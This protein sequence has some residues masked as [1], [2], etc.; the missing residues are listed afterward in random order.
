M[1]PLCLEAGDVVDWSLALVISHLH[2][3]D[4]TTT[5]E[6]LQTKTVLVQD[7]KLKAQIDRLL[8]QQT[9]ALSKRCSF[10]QKLKRTR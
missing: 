9:Q 1:H 10:L 6:Q 3:T 4:E 2:A 7:A 8:S 5:A